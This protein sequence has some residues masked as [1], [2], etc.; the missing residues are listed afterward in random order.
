LTII[1]LESLGI[2]NFELDPAII[3]GGD[4]A[5]CGW[6]SVNAMAACCCRDAA[7]FLGLFAARLRERTSGL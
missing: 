7:G 6:H 3:G 5:T 4:S 1:H 2:F